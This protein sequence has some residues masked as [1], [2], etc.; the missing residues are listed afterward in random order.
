MC[1]FLF[2]NRL[3]NHLDVH[4]VILLVVC[5]ERRIRSLLQVT[6]RWHT[7]GSQAVGKIQIRPKRGQDWTA[8][9]DRPFFY[10][11]LECLIFLVSYMQLHAIYIGALLVA[12]GECIR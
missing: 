3:G 9:S 5:N 12:V 1:C 2:V 4:E 7:Q 6:E 11:E 8:A 10:F